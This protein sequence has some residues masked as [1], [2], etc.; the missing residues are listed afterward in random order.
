MAGSLIW[1]ECLV[2]RD[3]VRNYQQLRR[4]YSGD[5]KGEALQLN[6]NNIDSDSTDGAAIVV[7][8]SRC[9]PGNDD[10]QHGVWVGGSVAPSSTFNTSVMAPPS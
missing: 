6:R 8:T 3:E 2:E 10:V 7:R 1:R 5:Q 9:V 4:T